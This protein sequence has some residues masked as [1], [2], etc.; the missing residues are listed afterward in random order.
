[1]LAVIRQVEDGPDSD[2]VSDR[3]CEWCIASWLPAIYLDLGIAGDQIQIDRISEGGF[4]TDVEET[5]NSE[6]GES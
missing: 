6:T 5:A 3:D 4:A 2:W 1:M